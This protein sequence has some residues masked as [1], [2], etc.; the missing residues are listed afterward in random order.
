MYARVAES[1]LLFVLVA[2]SPQRVLMELGFHL[3]HGKKGK[4]GYIDVPRQILKSQLQ[5]KIKV[6]LLTE[7]YNCF[8]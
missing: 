8:L 2:N 7:G 1:V 4:G 3:W 6:S 5:P